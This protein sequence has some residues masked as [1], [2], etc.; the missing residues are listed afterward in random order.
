[1]APALA[2]L[3]LALAV[4]TARAEDKPCT[5]RNNG[6]YYD[7]NPLQSSKDYSIKTP[8]GR[9]LVLSA[10]KAVSHET[11]G[12]KMPDEDIAKVAGFTQRAHGDFSL[13]ELNTTLT[14]SSRSGYP[15]LTYSKGSKCVDDQ[16]NRLDHL[17]ASTEIEFVCDPSAGKGTPRLIAQLPPGD[18]GAACAF[19][20]EWRT[21][22]ACATSE[23]WT[24]GSFIWFLFT[25]SLFLL[26]AYLV[27]GT[28]Y[29]YFALN[30][31]GGDLVPKFSATSMVY[32]SREAADIA[33]EWWQTSGPGRG[34][35]GLRDTGAS[36]FGGGFS[37]SGA[38]GFGRDAEIG[39]EDAPKPSNANA[40]IRTRK[41]P[42]AV[43]PASHHG[44]THSSAAAPPVLNTHSVSASAS[45]SPSHS[46]IPAPIPMPIPTHGLNPA[47][48]Q[49]QVMS[50]TG[51]G[52]EMGTPPPPRTSAGV[53]PSVMS[54]PLPTTNSGMPGM[55]MGAG[56]NPASH[57]AQVMSGMPVAHLSRPP[58]PASSTGAGAG[59][60]TPGRERFALGDEDGD[61]DEEDV[62][63]GAVKL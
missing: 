55:G 37:R 12:L 2:A 34:Q 22:S 9:D 39:A 26:A 53:G 42:T 20:F 36:G 41:D 1:M 52:T 47:S 62:P 60:M 56:L 38:N 54:P 19:V 51:P 6:K 33:R 24:F 44:Q 25:T 30:L 13:G 49:A 5:G 4:Q 18:D 29:N 15:H 28:L 63:G 11:W 8:G 31:R 14:F 16:G 50:N 27:I 46:P 3:L 59:A 21:S 43:N 58:A 32:H 45:P 40:F 48:H 23:G 57:Q 17:F 7:L 61:E 35:F 10:C